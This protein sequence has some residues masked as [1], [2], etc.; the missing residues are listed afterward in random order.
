[1][2]VGLDQLEILGHTGGETLV[3]VEL[4]FGGVVGGD[5]FTNGSTISFL[6]TNQLLARMVEVKF[7]FGGGCFVTGELELFNKVFV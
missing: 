7:D 4:E 3:T 1:M 5:I 2:L 6:N